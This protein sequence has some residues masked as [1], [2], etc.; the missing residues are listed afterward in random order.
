MRTFHIIIDQEKGVDT[1]RHADTVLK[2]LNQPGAYVSYSHGSGPAIIIVDA[3]DDINPDK[4]FT[5]TNDE[6]SFI[7]KYAEV[8]PNEQQVEGVGVQPGEASSNAG[9]GSRSKGK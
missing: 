7:L 4:A 2:S 5:I 6:G 3:P 1:D 9:A 8:K